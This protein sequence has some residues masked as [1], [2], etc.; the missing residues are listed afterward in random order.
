MVGVREKKK[1]RLMWWISD[2]FLEIPVDK[3]ISDHVICLEI[4]VPVGWALNTNN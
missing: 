2:L 3:I 1:Y 4:T